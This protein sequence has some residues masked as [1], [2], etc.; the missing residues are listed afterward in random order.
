MCEQHPVLIE[1]L[2][3]QDVMNL[4]KMSSSNLTQN[5]QQYGYRIL[6]QNLDI[7]SISDTDFG[8]SNRVQHTININDEVLSSKDTGE[9]RHQCSKTFKTIYNN[10]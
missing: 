3:N 5:Q 1:D 7:F 2:E 6:E 4:V 10:Y 8:H 9:S